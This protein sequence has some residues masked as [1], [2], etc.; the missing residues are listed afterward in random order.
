MK[1]FTVPTR[2]DVS[3]TNQ[4]I[5][6]NLTGALGMVPNLYASFAKNDTAL[7]DY[8]A[9]QSRKSTLKN[10]EKEIINLVVSQINNCEYCL[11]AHTM[12]AKMND[13]TDEQI[14]EIR[15]GAAA[16][17]SKLDALAKFTKDITINRGTPSTTALDTLLNAGYT[18]ANL[19][20]IVILIGDKTMA[21]FLHGIIKVPVDFPLA[22]KLQLATA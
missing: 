16:F 11:S 12:V 15:S 4:A 22:P 5:F 19:V 18:E 2:A 9:L 17:D 14:L 1:N 13:F 6:D 8:L 7:S 20:D 21:N 10:R 3:E